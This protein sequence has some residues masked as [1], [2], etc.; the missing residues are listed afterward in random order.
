MQD[1][2]S[3]RKFLGRAA[4]AGVGLWALGKGAFSCSAEPH[5]IQGKLLGPDF[6]SGHALRA[7]VAEHVP[8]R[9]LNTEVVIVGGGVAGLAC[10]WWLGQRGF[11]DFLLLEMEAESGGNARGGSQNGLRHPWGAHYLPVPDASNL[12]LMSF[13]Q[14]HDVVTGM[15]RDNRPIFNEL[16]LCHAPEERLQMHGVWQN[17]LVPNTGLSADERAQ[18]HRFF[19]EIEVWKKVIGSDGKR[20][21]AI[22]AEMSSQDPETLRLD[23]LTMAAYLQEK[24]YD[25]A[26]LKWYLDYCCRDDYGTTLQES[27]A[28]AGIHYFAART[29]GGPNAESG[30]VLTWPE[31][32]AWLIARLQQGLAANRKI[33]QR[34]MV[35]ALENTADGVTALVH[36]LV[37]PNDWARVSARAAVFSGPQFVAKHVVRGYDRSLEN[38]DYAPWLVANMRVNFEGH[39]LLKGIYWDNVPYGRNSL[40]YVYAGHQ[41]LT[42]YPP[43]EGVLTWYEP[44]THLSPADARKWLLEADYEVLKARVL[45]DM[46]HMH[47]G[48]SAHIQALDIWRWGHGMVRPVPGLL[49]GDGLKALREPIGKIHFAH[50]D[51]SGI[52]IFEEAFHRGVV[53]ADAVL[54]SLQTS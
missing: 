51:L 24:G 54:K 31:G 36:D 38:V 45:A 17:G 53:A 13:L 52:S 15:D 49:W 10:A 33:L 9:V 19:E 23:S 42:Q 48:I 16:Y 12:P 6:G 32:N 46:E 22:P 20:A 37:K 44:L 8:R 3:R 29:G 2:I 50:S 47:P 30:D 1:H 4:A 25:S 14:E 21:F 39:S 34:Q 40:G 28:W 41:T 26:H 35:F 27:S 5:V 18:I 43:R 7:P 11:H